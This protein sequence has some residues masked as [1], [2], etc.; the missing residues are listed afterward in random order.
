MSY[1]EFSSTRGYCNSKP[2][3]IINPITLQIVVDND[4]SLEGQHPT[5]GQV[6]GFDGT[7]V[8]WGDLSTIIEKANTVLNAGLT[9][10]PYSLAYFEQN[11]AGAYSR[12]SSDTSANR[13]FY[14]PSNNVL[15]ISNGTNTNQMNASGYTTRNSIQN[16][17]HY[18]NFSDNSATGTGAIQKTAGISCNPSTNSITATTFNGDLSGSIITSLGDI[19]MNTTAS[20]GNGNINIQSKATTGSIT[21]NTGVKTFMQTN[22]TTRIEVDGSTNGNITM[23]TAGG[24]LIGINQASAGGGSTNPILKLQNTNSSSADTFVEMYKN[25]TSVIGDIVGTIS[26]NGN[27][28]VGTKQSY[29]RIRTVINNNVTAATGADGAISLYALTN[30]SS[31]ECIRADGGNST[32]G[33]PAYVKT[34]VPLDTVGNAITT[35]T[36]NLTL[37]GLTNNQVVIKSNGTTVAGNIPSLVISGGTSTTASAPPVL[38]TAQHPNFNGEIYINR[39]SSGNVS[40][41]GSGLGG[42][43]LLS[44]PSASG[45]G[46]ITITNT[47]SQ[48]QTSIVMGSVT[49]GSW[50]NIFSSSPSFGRIGCN[51]YAGHRMRALGYSVSEQASTTTLTGNYFG[52]ATLSGTPSQAVISCTSIGANDLIFLTPIGVATGQVVVLSQTVGTGFTIESTLAGD[53]R[54]VNYMVVISVA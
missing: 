33:T 37:N 15:T 54:V 10:G 21:L 43:T 53:T 9:G 26:M 29:G 50:T 45:S 39:V 42:I 17:T 11:T 47:G 1:N 25:R 28:S 18:L 46:N 49:M 24:G 7:N 51:S 4:D 27:N 20:L 8:V 6:M 12:L 16:S 5:L 40:I 48:H 13:L 41:L 3:P 31:V 52:R 32:A 36:G 34:I 30:G 2:V 23:T 38:I 19:S 22:S 44:N 35:T 14:D